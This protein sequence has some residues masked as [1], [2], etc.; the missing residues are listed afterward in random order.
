MKGRGI[1]GVGKLCHPD[2][3]PAAPP[4]PPTNLAEGAAPPGAPPAPAA[5]LP[6]AAGAGSIAG[7]RGTGLGAG[8]SQQGWWEDGC[9]AGGCGYPERGRGCL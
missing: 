8:G 9:P 1:G 5:L 7:H 4:P 2:P 6:A 3:H